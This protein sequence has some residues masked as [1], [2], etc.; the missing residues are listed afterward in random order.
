MISKAVG[1]DVLGLAIAKA[2]GVDTRGVISLSIECLAG[3]VASLTITRMIPEDK[4][5]EIAEL[6]SRYALVRAEQ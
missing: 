6:V 5:G 3:K 4:S 2:L 1:S